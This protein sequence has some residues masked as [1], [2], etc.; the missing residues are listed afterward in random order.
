MPKLLGFQEWKVSHSAVSLL[1]FNFPQILETLS[2]PLPNSV[3][4]EYFLVFVV[5]TPFLRLSLGSIDT[6]F[7]TGN[8]LL[9]TTL[10]EP[11]MTTWI[12]D[13]SS[14]L[15]LFIFLFRLKRL[16]QTSDSE[17]ATLTNTT[18]HF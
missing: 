4:S 2:I 9:E 14:H 15:S 1:R 13:I 16:T 17:M 18:F 12:V 7:I 10:S 5:M 8:S 3:A 6:V 11:N